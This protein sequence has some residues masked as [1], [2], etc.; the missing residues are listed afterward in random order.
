MVMMRIVENKNET[1]AKKQVKF[2][3]VVT[4]IHIPRLSQ[5]EKDELFWKPQD[6]QRMKSEDQIHSTRRARSRLRE[7]QRRVTEASLHAKQMLG[8]KNAED[9]GKQ[10][11][12]MDGFQHTDSFRLTQKPNHAQEYCI[13]NVA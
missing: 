3:E 9:V 12:A 6:F 5:E 10:R 2:C 4:I 7:M 11:C 13:A 8:E 1:V